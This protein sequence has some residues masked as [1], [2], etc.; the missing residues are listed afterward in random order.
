MKSFCKSKKLPCLI[1]SKYV[2]LER[3]GHETAPD[4]QEETKN[5]E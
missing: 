2:F 4:H 5:M 3:L 1:M